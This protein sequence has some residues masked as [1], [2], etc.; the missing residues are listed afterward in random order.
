MD[1]YSGD[2]IILA[3]LRWSSSKSLARDKELSLTWDILA[4]AYTK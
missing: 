2:I 3:E 4:S 1:G